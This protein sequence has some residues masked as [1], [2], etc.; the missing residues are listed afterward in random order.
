MLIRFDP[1]IFAGFDLP[2]L[3]EPLKNLSSRL[4]FCPPLWK[5]DSYQLFVKARALIHAQNDRI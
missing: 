1:V 3:S 2:S 4:I 5:M